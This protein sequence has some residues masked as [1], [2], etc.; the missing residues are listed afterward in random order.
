M[1]K[2]EYLYTVLME[3][4]AEVSQAASK[5][6]RFGE[7]GYNPA[8]RPLKYNSQSLLEE[9]CHLA[10]AIEM[11]QES[12]YLPLHLLSEQD[13]IQAKKDK[14]NR[15]LDEYLKQQDK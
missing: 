11:L 5:V 8:A 10:A 15:Y 12:G 7:Q 13:L 3:E 1:T 2:R 9:Y 6:M 4:C 14:V